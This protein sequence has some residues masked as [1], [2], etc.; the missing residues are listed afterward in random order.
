MTTLL[1]RPRPQS[2]ESLAGYLLRLTSRNGLYFHHLVASAGID[3]PRAHPGQFLHQLDPGPLAALLKTDEAVLQ[4]M[5]YAVIA[6]SG[7]R[8]TS[9]DHHGIDMP[10]A[11]VSTTA[12]PFCPACLAE[13]SKAVPAYFRTSWDCALTPVCNKHKC[14]LVDACPTCQEPLRWHRR[15]LLR[16]PCQ[17]SHADVAVPLCAAAVVRAKPI[18]LP[19]D[20]LGVRQVALLAAFTAMP[21]RAT[22]SWEQLV[23]LPIPIR[24]RHVRAAAEAVAGGD[25]AM[26]RLARTAMRARRQTGGA[27]GKDWLVLPLL[28]GIVGESDLNQWARDL[29][30]RLNHKRERASRRLAVQ[31]VTVPDAAILAGL[32]PGGL[33]KHFG[34]GLSRIR[35]PEGVFVDAESFAIWLHRRATGLFSELLLSPGQS[36][37]RAAQRAVQRLS[38]ATA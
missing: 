14:E 9:V 32:T 27:L 19:T 16:C 18:H 10:A 33:S 5:A 6:K 7:R 26:L 23:A 25:A 20:G 37:Y 4:Q 3:R 28:R 12:S 13:D 24:A 11:L 29:V 21:Y 17:G 1:T 2:E 34:R 31:L 22:I 38:V 30:A 8:A 35:L 15:H 36:Q